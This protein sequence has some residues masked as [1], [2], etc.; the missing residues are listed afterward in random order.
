M[1]IHDRPLFASFV[2]E[3]HCWEEL[4]VAKLF[5]FLHPHALIGNLSPVRVDNC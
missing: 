4:V 1:R 3:E 5:G 2:E